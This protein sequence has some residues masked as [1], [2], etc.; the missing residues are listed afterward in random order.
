MPERYQR[1]I[2]SRVYTKFADTSNRRGG[3]KHRRKLLANMSGRV[4]ELGA[5]SGANFTHYPASVD[6]VLAVEPEPYLRQQ[7]LMAATETSVNIRVLDGDAYRL[8]GD[9]G[10]F[11]AWRCLARPL[12]RSRPAARARRAVPSHQTRGR[13]AF[14]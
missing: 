4:V 3:G 10:T 13:T 9:E 5:G 14:L 1:P 8:P 12:H 2:F 6:E 7:A 11:E